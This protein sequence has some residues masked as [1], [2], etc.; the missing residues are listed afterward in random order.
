MITSTSLLTV[1]PIRTGRKVSVTIRTTIK[2]MTDPHQI[3]HSP[4]CCCQDCSWQPPPTCT[5]S[6]ASQTAQSPVGGTAQKAD[7]QFDLNYVVL[8][9]IV[10]FF[11]GVAFTFCLFSFSNNSE[12][13][14]TSYYYQDLNS[15]EMRIGKSPID[16]EVVK[17]VHHFQKFPFGEIPGGA[18]KNEVRKTELIGVRDIISSNVIMVCVI[19]T[20]LFSFKV[21]IKS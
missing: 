10:A 13:G 3:I 16:P 12:D 6:I 11:V 17:S 21:C 5:H 15:V 8:C 2:L 14:S 19:M 7:T 18:V 4:S 20:M 1:V 9:A